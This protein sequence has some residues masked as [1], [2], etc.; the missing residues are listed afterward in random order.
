MELAESTLESADDITAADTAPRPKKDTKSGVRYCSTI[1]SIILVSSVVNGYGPVYAVSFQAT[2]D[3]VNCHHR[4][5][6][7]NKI[8]LHVQLKELL[9]NLL[10]FTYFANNRV[11]SNN[12]F[13]FFYF[14][15]HKHQTGLL[16]YLDRPIFFSAY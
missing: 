6:Y 3:E 9:I 2:T 14:F 12:F 10:K 4:R 8:V 7:D 1:G 16:Q 11:Y 5:T 15:S 13:F